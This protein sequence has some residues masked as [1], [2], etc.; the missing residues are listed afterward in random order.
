MELREVLR[1]LRRWAW[2]LV[3]GP[4]V[5][6]VC[7]YLGLRR[8]GPWPA[9]EAKAIVVVDGEQT[10]INAAQVLRAAYVELADEDFVVRRVVDSLGLSRQPSDLA[11]SIRIN[12]VGQTQLVEI[13]VTDSSAPYAAAVANEMAYQLTQIT[14]TA[15]R[16]LANQSNVSILS[17]A[18]VPT[19]PSLRSYTL[20]LVAGVLGLLLAT[21]A[22]LLIEQLDS[23]IRTPH[24]IEQ[25]V[26]LPVLGVIRHKHKTRL[27]R[28]PAPL[29]GQPQGPLQEEVEPANGSSAS[30]TQECRWMW[31]YI[32]QM[33]DGYPFR[34]LVTSP[35]EATNRATFSADL[36]RIWAEIGQEVVFM[37]VEPHHTP[38]L[39]RF[40]CAEDDVVDSA[41]VEEGADR[42]ADNGQ[43]GAHVRADVGRAIPTRAPGRQL[44]MP[45][46]ASELQTME[47]LR[48]ST[49]IV[50]GP[51]VL[52]TADAALW[53]T[54]VDVTLLVCEGGK[55]LIEEARK[56][57]D[58]LTKAGAHV[59]GAVLL[60]GD[61]PRLRRDAD[62]D[63]TRV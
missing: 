17:V 15:P 12:P 46:P 18:D 57:K 10:D 42:G 56:A 61:Y 60:S 27:G 62:H 1:L 11:R 26:G 29:Q 47:A 43:A 32:S 31:V 50:D 5:A 2:L 59:V 55:T 33:V 4:I 14:L 38:E 53:A 54:Q 45:L 8:F 19:D 52:V 49:V 39:H 25:R 3:A 28:L 22:V 34:M 48:A 13:I 6:M 36:A 44:G 40:G 37:K 9:Y 51:P 41:L 58:M 20:I 24:D 30:V 16:S 23:T 21:G 35:M 7:C 63:Q